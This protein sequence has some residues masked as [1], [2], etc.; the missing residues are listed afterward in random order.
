MARPK[1]KNELLEAAALNYDKLLKL[2]GSMTEIELSTEFDF[3][4]DVTK[5]EAHWKRDKNVRDILIHL[6]EWHNL[7]LEWVTNNKAGVRKLFLMEGYNW[8]SYGEMNIVF[9]KRNQTVS[10]DMALQKLKKSHNEIINMIQSM[11]NDELFQKNVYEW[12]GGSTIGSYFI[13]V[14]SSHYDW[15]IKKIKAHIKLINDK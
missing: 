11:S 10:L 15:A 4:S 14:T 12:V 8:K 9:W 2:I 3:S 13:S 5:K 7:M 6:H 1:T